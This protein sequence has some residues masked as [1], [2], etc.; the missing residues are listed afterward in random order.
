MVRTMVATPSTTK[1]HTTLVR[2]TKS[3]KKKINRKIKR[4]VW[5][6][7]LVLVCVLSLLSRSQ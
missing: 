6:V 3:E 2:L 4:L 1:G 7:F 5:C